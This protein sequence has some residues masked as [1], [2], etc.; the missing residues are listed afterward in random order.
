MSFSERFNNVISGV[1]SGLVI[2]MIAFFAFY[3]ATSN[4][5]SLVNYY[6]KCIEAGNLTQIISVCV[7]V[8]IAAFLLFNRFDMLR[9]SKG[10]LGIT[11]IW[12]LFVFG[13][14]I[15]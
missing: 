3:L 8:N 14:K 6:R 7:F 11:I 15:F 12:A 9:A 10:V 4:G 2:P 1:L 13:I 5:L